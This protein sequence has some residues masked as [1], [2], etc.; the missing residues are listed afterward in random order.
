MSGSARTKIGLSDTFWQR[1]KRHLE[2][3]AETP[4]TALRLNCAMVKINQMLRNREAKAKP[5][6]LPGHR[7][8]SLL[9]RHEQRIQPV[10]FN[11]NAVV[12]NVKMESAALAV[13]GADGDLSP[14]WRE[15]HRVVDQVPKY[16][17]KPNALSPNAIFFRVQFGRELQF[18]RRDG[19]TCG[20]NCVANNRV[21]VATFQLKVN[22]PRVT[23][24]RSRR[25][26]INRACNCTLRLMICISS[27]NSDGS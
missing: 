20:F 6:K 9:K 11:S 1:V 16:L 15:F 23:R 4:A 8:I 26:S 7:S 14:R 25:S 2:S 24:V 27:T 19:G 13:V 22:L 17:L 3:G 12:S 18:L 10:G 5:A 21:R